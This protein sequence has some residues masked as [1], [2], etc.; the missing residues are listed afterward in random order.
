MS[1]MFES[2]LWASRPVILVAV[3]AGV[4]LALRAFW[5]ALVD[6]YHCFALLVDHADRSLDP[7]A[8]SDLRSDAVTTMV[9]AL[10]APCPCHPSSAAAGRRRSG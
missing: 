5:V 4:V 6:V 3:V 10:A 1:N 8:Y 2:G 7:R 9:K